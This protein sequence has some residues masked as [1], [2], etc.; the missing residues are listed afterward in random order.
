MLAAAERPLPQRK[1]A[2]MKQLRCPLWMAG[3]P[4]SFSSQLLRR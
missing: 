3:A 2:Q 1:R 4:T